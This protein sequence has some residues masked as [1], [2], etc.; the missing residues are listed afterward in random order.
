MRG[1][2]LPTFAL[3]VLAFALWVYLF[4]SYLGIVQ[5]DLDFPRQILQASFFLSNIILVLAWFLCG[6]VWFAVFASTLILLTV[7]LVLYLGEPGLWVQVVA[8][9][10]GYLWLEHLSRQIE[11]EKLVHLVNWERVQAKLNLSSKGLEEREQLLTALG[12]KLERLKNLREFTD[13]LKDAASLKE[14]SQIVT[15]EVA[16]LMPRADQILLF[17]I[18]EKTRDLGLVSQVSRD[19]KFEAREKRGNEYDEWVIRRSQPLLI[20]DVKNDFRF[21]LEQQPGAFRSVCLV[22]LVS[23][24]KVFG[25]LHLNA[26]EPGAFQTDD[27]RFIDIVADMSAV[28]LRNVL[29]YEK[30]MELAIVDS[31]TECYLFRY[32]QERLMEEIQ[33]ALRNKTPFSVIMAD[34]DHFKKYNDELGHQAGDM[35]LKGIAEILRTSAGPSDIVGR[36]GGEEFVILAPLKERAEAVEMAERLRSKVESRTFDLRR[37]SRRITISLGVATFPQDGTTKEDILWKSD[38]NLYEAKKRGRNR[39]VG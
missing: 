28:A 7:Y 10:L 34:I 19:G 13:R 3:P 35:V 14:M 9:L 17:V 29:L 12:R 11:N 20:E 39:T 6:R 5:S 37:E 33:R 24:R 4:L 18:D 38:K 2:P 15:Q 25:V 21:S 23:E 30:T 1:L 8:V 16:R 22:P 36:Y 27:L 32:V 31:L 26:T